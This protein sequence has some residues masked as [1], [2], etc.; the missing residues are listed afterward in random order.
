MNLNQPWPFI[1]IWWGV[2][3]HKEILY[4][5]NLSGLLNFVGN[6][7]G[8]GV[9]GQGHQS[10][11]CTRHVDLGEVI[12]LSSGLRFGRSTYKF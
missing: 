8:T 7:G 10:D 6:R 2:L 4:K 5:P 11:R 1:F 9:T 3:P 12:F